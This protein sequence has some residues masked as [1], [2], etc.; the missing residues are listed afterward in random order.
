MRR[1][2]RRARSSL[3]DDPARVEIGL[4]ALIRTGGRAKSAEKYLE[5]EGVRIPAYML[6]KW[7]I[8]HAAEYDALRETHAAE[9]E[10][11]LAHDWRD[12]ARLAVDGS[13]LAVEA[14]IENLE[15]GKDSDPA[16]TAAN[17]AKVAQSSTDKLLALTGRPTQI[18]ETRNAG[19][20]I[21]KLVQL[22]VVK[23]PDDPLEIEQADG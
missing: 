9:I 14:A 23:V 16:R 6:H 13:A 21:R 2:W 1:R 5:D 15:S 22:G 7:K 18:T 12:N 4:K 10:A 11:H 20:I 19:E 8:S 3:S 17:L